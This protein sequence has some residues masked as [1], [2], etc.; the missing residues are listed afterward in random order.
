M[1]AAGMVAR[2]GGVSQ[3]A[4]DS[5]VLA[6][7]TRLHIHGGVWAA[8]ARALKRDHVS[9]EHSRGPENSNGKP[10]LTHKRPHVSYAP[11]D[12]AE[13]S[14]LHVHWLR[15]VAALQIS[16]LAKSRANCCCSP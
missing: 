12:P 15:T 8:L 3:R 9:C 13:L 2:S 14:R 1:R 16:N 10:Q 4:P 6:C 11:H 7:D 5:C